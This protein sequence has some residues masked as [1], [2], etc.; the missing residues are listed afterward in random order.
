MIPSGGLDAYAVEHRRRV[1]QVEVRGGTAEP[2]GSAQAAFGRPP[3]VGDALL[4]GFELP[5]EGL[6]IRVTIE[7][8]RADGPD[9]DP[10]DPPLVWEASG[11]DGEW[12]EAAIVAD[13]TGGF[14][15][16]SGTVTVEVPA[17]A[18]AT[19]IAGR[20]LHWLRCRVT[21]R[22]RGGSPASYT[23]APEISTL[24]AAVVGATVP[25]CHAATV[26]E[27]LIGTSEGIPGATYRLQHRPVLELREGETLEVRER[28]ADRWVA[29]RRV[30]SFEHS[31]ST[32]RHFVLDRA[33]GEIRFGPAIR[34]PDGGWRRFGAVPPGG[35]AMRMRSYRHGGGRDGNVAP[36]T[37]S[38]LAAPDRG[39]R[40]A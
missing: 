9:L 16:G 24:T 2:S 7:S 25:A 10:A 17:G 23:R 20:E 38:I 11:A 22:G 6:V 29:W 33:V 21:G 19:A 13:D 8:S 3:S 12:Y 32:D 36:R 5:I 34:Q 40:R 27:E 28:G 35:A 15:F 37:L 31:G 1:E 26:R 18:G 39:C 4:L 30:D 14:L